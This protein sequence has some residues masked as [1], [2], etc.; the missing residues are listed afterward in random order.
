MASNTQSNPS[1]KSYDG[2]GDSNADVVII[3]VDNSIREESAHCRKV[4]DLLRDVTRNVQTFRDIDAADHYI[5]DADAVRIF[6]ITSGA[7][8]QDLMKKIHSNALVDGVY[9]FCRNP[10]YHRPW[11]TEYDK[12]KKIERTIEPIVAHIQSVLSQA[13]PS[14]YAV[15]SRWPN[16]SSRPAG[17]DVSLNS[18]V[19]TYHF[20]HRPWR[21]SVAGF[22][23]ILRRK[24]QRRRCG[25]TAD[26]R[27]WS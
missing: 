24:L 7:F 23:S 16:T 4:L 21:S 19:Q 12:I 27:I 18:V 3:W 13:S 5:R 25:F 22:R 26:R 17:P 20:D 8:G 15:Q 9:I 10:D 14:K 11:A 2:D 1:K 6:V